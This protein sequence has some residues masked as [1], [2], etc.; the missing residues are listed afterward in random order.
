MG[1]K[2]PVKMGRRIREVVD[3]D[4]VRILVLD[5]MSDGDAVIQALNKYSKV[6][7]FIKTIR[8]KCIE[9]IG[10]E[11]VT[12]DCML[13]NIDENAFEFLKSIGELDV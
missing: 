1:I 2:L 4:H 3:A 11:Q 12:Q 10:D 7:K 9:V 8:T 13:I 6:V 5:D